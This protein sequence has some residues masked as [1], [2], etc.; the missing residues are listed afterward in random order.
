MAKDL[1]TFLSDAKAAGMLHTIDAEVDT[2]RNVGVLCD[3]SDKGLL[4]KNIKGYEGWSVAAN[5]VDNRD[6]E[7]V[8]FGVKDRTDVVRAMAAAMDRGP[9]PHVYDDKPPCQEVVW[10]GE[11]ADLRRLPMVRHSELDGGPYMGNAIGIVNDPETGH[12]NTTWPRLM[13]GDAKNAPFLIFSPHV[14]QIAGKY[15]KMGKPMPMALCIGNHPGV[16][17]A[18]SISVHHPHCGELDFASAI[19]G[20]QMKFAKT[21]LGI[22]VPA[23]SEIVI[24]GET[25]LNHVADEGPFG[26]YLGTYCSGPLSRDGVQKAP[27]FKVKRITTRKN[28]IYRHLQSTVFTEHQRLCMLPMEGVLFNALKEMGVDV[29]DVYIPS[30]GGCSATIIQMTPRGPGEAQDVLLKA[31]MWENTTLSFMSQLCVTVNKDVNIYDPRDV[32]WALTIRANYTENL[33]VI[34]GTRSSPLMPSAKKVPG[35]PYRRSGK[36]LIDATVLPAKDETEWWEINRAWPMGKGKYSITDFVKEGGS[37]KIM[38]RLVQHAEAIEMKPGG[39]VP[40]IPA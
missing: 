27:V 5:L 29:H 6:M 20:E 2:Q 25:I 18:A 26:N 21:P 13:G 28:P 12:H 23:N 31:A 4:F 35:V 37:A 9:S 10:E 16:D 34:P 40:E 7:K 3:E 8:V 32:F 22:D 11:D 39:R 14:G 38:K 15:A 17:V 24:E 19:L 1:R 30:W 33:H 36:A